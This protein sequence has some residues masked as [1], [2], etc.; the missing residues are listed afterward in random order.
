MAN[1]T[2]EPV[3]LLYH[4]LP[5]KIFLTTLD[6]EKNPCYINKGLEK[7]APIV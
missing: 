3:I 4:D 1:V 2:L 7:Q 6:T 5:K